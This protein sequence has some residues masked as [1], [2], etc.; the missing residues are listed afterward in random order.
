MARLNPPRPLRD[1]DAV[2]TFD[3]GRESMNQWFRRHARHNQLHNNS[4]TTVLT[5]AATGVIAG[6]VTLAAA[7]IE[8][9]YLPR[10]A[11]RNRPAA[12]PVILLGQLAV[13][14]RHQGLG[15]ARQLLFHALKTGLALSR[16]V[17]CFGV[18]TH[19]LDDEVRAFHARFGFVD[20]PGDPRRTMIVRI[21]DLEASGFGA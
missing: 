18:I 7:Q 5:D 2:E 21:A 9:E 14:R 12:I 4:R 8:R 10:A 6:Y 16:Q 17:G 1:D 3:C 19:P 15:I 20:L 13:D 11:Q